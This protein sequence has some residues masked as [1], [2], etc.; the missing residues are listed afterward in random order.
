MQNNPVSRRVTVTG[1]PA[2]DGAVYLSP[3]FNRIVHGWAAACLAPVHI[4][5]DVTRLADSDAISLG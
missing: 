2:I 1:S 5:L 4:A 3:C